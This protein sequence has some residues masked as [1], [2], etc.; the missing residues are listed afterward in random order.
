LLQRHHGAA[1]LA[2][3]ATALN[4][5]LGN[6]HHGLDEALH[7]NG[8][9]SM[10]GRHRVIHIAVA[11]QRHRAD[12]AGSHVTGFE[13]ASRQ[14]TECRKIGQEPL[15]YRLTLAAGRLAQPCQAVPLQGAVE[16][17]KGGG[18]RHRG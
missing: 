1:P 9:V 3:F 5:A 7:Q 14:R 17:R 4:S 12:P 16:V 6:D 15:A 10:S 13:Q 8:G 2:D 11:N 18:R